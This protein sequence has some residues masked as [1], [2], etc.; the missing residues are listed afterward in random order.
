MNFRKQHSVLLRFVKL[1]HT[2]FQC[3]VK[4]STPDTHMGSVWFFLV[5]SCET[6]LQELPLL[7][8]SSPCTE[9]YASSHLLCSFPQKAGARGFERD[10]SR[11]PWGATS[12]FLFSS[13]LVSYTIP[14][15][16][17]QAFPLPIHEC[18]HIPVRKALLLFS[19]KCPRSSTAESSSER[20][21]TKY[22]SEHSIGNPV[23]VFVKPVLSLSPAPWHLFQRL[24]KSCAQGLS[25]LCVYRT[26]GK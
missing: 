21:K 12:Q 2:G 9:V 20:F 6:L 25:A 17:P 23:P 8:L 10:R 24:L 4:C 19:L 11:L 22:D 1:F 13:C 7:A 16:P 5:R 26:L 18:L 15:L 3:T 14:F